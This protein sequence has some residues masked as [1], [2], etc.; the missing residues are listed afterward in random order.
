MERNNIYL[1]E[2]GDATFGVVG[3]K[4]MEQN[5]GQTNKCGFLIRNLLNK[6]M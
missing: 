6:R 1:H 2:E 5:L 3:V 4:G